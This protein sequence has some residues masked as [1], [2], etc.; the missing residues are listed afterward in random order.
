MGETHRFKHSLNAPLASRNNGIN[1]IIG[2]FHQK[3]LD[4]LKKAFTAIFI[5]LILN[6]IFKMLC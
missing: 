6:Q 2:D 1:I 3:F 5:I 4:I